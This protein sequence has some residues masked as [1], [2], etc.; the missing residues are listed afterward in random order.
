MLLIHIDEKISL[1]IP[2]KDKILVQSTPTSL[3]EEKTQWRQWALIFCVNVH[4]KLDPLPS[5]WTL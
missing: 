5:V 2:S 3:H 4:M 1:S